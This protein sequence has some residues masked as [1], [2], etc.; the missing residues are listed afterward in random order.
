MKDLFLSLLKFA[1]FI[2]LILAAAY[3]T[4]NWDKL[5]QFVRNMDTHISALITSIQEAI[6][7][8][9]THMTQLM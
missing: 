5:V 8:V 1:F 9:K 3:L 7:I 2:A 6:T 4:G